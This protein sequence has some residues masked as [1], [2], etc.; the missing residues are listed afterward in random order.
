MV[1][2]DSSFYVLIRSPI[3]LIIEKRWFYRLFQSHQ[4][5]QFFW[6][7]YHKIDR[8]T[9]KDELINDNSESLAHYFAIGCSNARFLKSVSKT[10]A[11]APE[12][13]A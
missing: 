10:T 12:E 9:L 4:L 6:K 1:P 5:K 3:E 2:H 8:P 11:L 13:I 7:D